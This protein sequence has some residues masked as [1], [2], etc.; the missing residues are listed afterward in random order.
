M[1]SIEELLYYIQ[2]SDAVFYYSDAKTPLSSRLFLYYTKIR[3]NC[4]V[5]LQLRQRCDMSSGRRAILDFY[6]L[7]P[8]S[9]DSIMDG[10][11]HNGLGKYTFLVSY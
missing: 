8:P 11:S 4:K 2:L 6:T 5:Y 10:I 9:K 7:L 1:C 3:L